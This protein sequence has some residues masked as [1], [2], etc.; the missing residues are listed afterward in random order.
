MSITSDNTMFI[1]LSFEGP[2]VYS[3]VGGLGARV[4]HLADTLAGMGFQVHHI[5]I[6]DP[7]L[8]GIEARNEGKLVLHRWCQWISRYHPAGVYDGEEGKLYD[9][10][11]S[12]PPFIVHE[13]AIPAIRQ[14]KLVVVMG[15][16]WQTAEAVC[17]ISE[18][19]SGA[20]LQ[21]RA[22][23]FW[24]ANSTY[25]F[26]RI[27]WG[28]LSNA[29]TITTV[30]KYM[31]QIMLKMGINPLVIPNGIPKAVITEVNE[32][33]VSMLRELVHADLVLTK[34]ARWH[35]DK[36]WETVIQV[37]DSL[38]KSGRSP[39]L[40]AR[41]GTDPYGQRIAQQAWSFGL[42]MKSLHLR[43]DPKEHYQRAA[44]EKEF[45]PYFDA[46]SRVGSGDILNLLF[47]IP[48]S[49]LQ[50]IYQA[51]DVVLANSIHE[52]FGLVGLEAMAAGAVVFC[53]SSGEDYATHM[54]NAI[55][56]D[57]SSAE[58]IKFYITYLHAHPETRKM[59]GKAARRTAERCTWEEVVKTLLCKLEYQARLQGVSL[60]SEPEGSATEPDLILNSYSTPPPPEAVQYSL[61]SVGSK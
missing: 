2:D 13:L 5:F 38:R 26:D 55:V 61:L 36:G 39:I 18:L 30:S 43:G 59:I 47:P 34:V 9:F 41:G 11:R 4:S 44:L 31:K 37:M 15:E 40:L 53:G 21:G 3:M 56:L 29:A 45:S 50:V 52:P 19:L 24:N 16:E 46:I 7:K 35:P 48:P 33:D 51:S 25:S 20:G 32:G 54:Y 1:V 57:T 12:A 49:F 17:R 10:T 8:E 23:I 42:K 28:R 58:E 27:D 14:G 22:V 6:G 60:P